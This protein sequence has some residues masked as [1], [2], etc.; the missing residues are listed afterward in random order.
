MSNGDFFIGKTHRLN[1]FYSIQFQMLTSNIIFILFYHCIL[2]KKP[3]K[4]AY[5]PLQKPRKRNGGEA[6]FLIA[7]MR[8][9]NFGPI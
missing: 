7:N 9:R 1:I 8:A 6:D 2:M 4:I 5:L 3:I